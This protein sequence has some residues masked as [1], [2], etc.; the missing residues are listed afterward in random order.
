MFLCLISVFYLLFF[1]VSFL[2]WLS[3]FSFFS[4]LCLCLSVSLFSLYCFCVKS[5][6]RREERN[7]HLALFTS[8]SLLPYTQKL[9]LRD[10]GKALMNGRANQWD[11][12]Y[13]PTWQ[14]IG[15]T[16]KTPRFSKT[17]SSS[18]SRTCTASRSAQESL[19]SLPVPLH[20]S[21]CLMSLQCP[22]STSALFTPCSSFE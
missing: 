1:S 5:V 13:Q 18:C 11:Y 2:N 21:S 19:N 9:Y 20:T 12:S 6:R 7:Y 10:G 15:V 4:C 14:E 22:L 17:I 16:T 8:Q 3:V